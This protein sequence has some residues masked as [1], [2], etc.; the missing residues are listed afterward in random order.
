MRTGHKIYTTFV[1]FSTMTSEKQRE[2]LTLTL[3]CFSEHKIPN[4]RSQFC[5]VE[6]VGDI[7]AFI[8]DTDCCP[9][10]EEI[11]K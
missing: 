4:C 6:D 7:P 11:H 8:L 9:V 1:L 2:L 5:S 3:A 10:E